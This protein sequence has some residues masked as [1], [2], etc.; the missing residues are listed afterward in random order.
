MK[1]MFVF[2][3]SS[4][5][6]KIDIEASLELYVIDQLNKS[7]KSMKI[8]NKTYKITLIVKFFFFWH[9]EKT[10]IQNYVSDSLHRG[11]VD[12]MGKIGSDTKEYG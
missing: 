1:E 3:F 5:R 2:K 12:K 7:N 8:S 10:K 4:S 11:K 6:R 9:N